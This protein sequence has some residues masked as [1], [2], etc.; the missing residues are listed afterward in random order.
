M[1]IPP[2]NY[3]VPDCHR[4]GAMK[5]EKVQR[6]WKEGPVGHLTLWK[7]PLTMGDKLLG[8]FLVYLVISTGPGSRTYAAPTVR[9]VYSYLLIATSHTTTTGDGKSSLGVPT[10]L[11]CPILVIIAKASLSGRTLLGVSFGADRH[12]TLLYCREKSTL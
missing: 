8:T 11:R 3:A 1:S 4:P 12:N 7:T 2:G 6:A 10:S 5:S 9:L